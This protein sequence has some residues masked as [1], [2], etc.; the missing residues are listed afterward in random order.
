MFKFI[1]ISHF[2]FFDQLDYCRIRYL[3]SCI[4]SCFSSCNSSCCFSCIST[5][6]Y[7]CFTSWCFSSCSSSCYWWCFSSWCFTSCSSRCWSSICSCWCTCYWPSYLSCLLAFSYCQRDHV[8]N[9]W[10]SQFKAFYCRLTSCF[11]SCSPSYLSWSCTSNLSGCPTCSL[12]SNHACCL[13][14]RL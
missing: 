10:S 13:S 8:V 7:P 3:F 9:L 11:T 12:T 14:C 6:G 4:W 1:L 2:F 5:S